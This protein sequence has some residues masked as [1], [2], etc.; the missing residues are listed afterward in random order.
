M[1]LLHYFVT[2]IIMNNYSDW[3]SFTDWHLD[4]VFSREWF[5][6][7][8]NTI[9]NIVWEIEKENGSLVILDEQEE[10]IHKLCKDKVEEY[11]LRYERK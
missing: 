3:Y 2:N 5:Y 7:V 10:D 1:N 9:N 11:L 4:L 8:T 6:G